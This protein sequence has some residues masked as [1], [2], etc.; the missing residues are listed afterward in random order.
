MLVLL[1]LARESCPV[2]YHYVSAFV[3]LLACLLVGK[4]GQ[5]WLLLRESCPLT[6]SLLL[7]CFLFNRL[8]HP[9]ALCSTAFFQLVFVYNIHPPLP[10][11]FSRPPCSAS[12]IASICATA[13]TLRRASRRRHRRPTISPA[14]SRR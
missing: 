11:W 7:L 1:M 12:T 3:C 4:E 8:S 10:P 2:I 6:V 13:T 9:L 14:P 5:R